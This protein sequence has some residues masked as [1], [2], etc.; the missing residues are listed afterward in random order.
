MEQEL[1][2]CRLCKCTELVE[3]INLGHQIIT[4][5]FPLKGDTSTPSAKI[6]IIQCT[7]C[8][9][10]QL[11]DTT[12]SSE[13]YEDFYGYRSGIN[14]TMRNHLTS[15]NEQLQSYANLVPGDT[16]LDIGSNDC[17]F[18]GHYPSTVRRIG[19]DPTGTQFA[20]FYKATGT[21][22]VPT[23][24][25][26]AAITASL[27][28]EVRFKSVSSISMFYDLPDP[29]Q[30]A[31]DIYDRLE[32]DGVWTLEQSYVATMLERNSIDTVCH[33][34]L[35]YYGVKQIKEIMDRVGFK[36][37]DL[38]LNDCNGGSFRTFVAKRSSIKFQE[39]TELVDRILAKEEADRI[40]TPERYAEFMKTCSTEVAKLN[41]FL[42]L[43][44]QDGKVTYIYGASTKGNC[45]LQFANIDSSKTPYAVERNPLKVGRITATGVEI[46][47]E[48]TMRQNPPDYMLVLPWH[49]RKEMIEREHAFLE[50]G[51]QLLFPFPSFEV[52]SS[53]PKTLI[54]GIDGQ[55]GQHLVKTLGSTVNLYGI[56]KSAAASKG[57]LRIRS[58]LTDRAALESLLC[59]IR[60]DQL[61]HLASLSNTEECEA[62]PVA[63]LDLNAGVVTSLCDIV[64]RNKLPTKLFHA[65]SS[66]LFKGHGNYVIEE[67]DTN[68]RP[69]T[70]YAICKAAGHSV[71]DSYR[72][73][74]G[75]P[76]SNGILF[77]TE[78]KLRK[79]TFLLKKVALHAKAV[80][81]G[82]NEP[83]VLGSLT[84]YRTI[85][86]ASDVAAAI[87]LVL[88]Q[89]RGD[90]YLICAP[91]SQTTEELVVVIYK[92]HGILLEKRDTD[93]YNRETGALV[94][95]TNRNQHSRMEACVKITGHCQRLAGLGWKP[96]YTVADVLAD[97]S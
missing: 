19:C 81:D 53:K 8:K 27:G 65:S 13:L 35:E 20:D 70:M 46:I 6:R 11:K 40:H 12:H 59:L 47:S 78:S 30:F 80:Q 75:L 4:S 73:R 29:V 26:K 79:P 76:F 51:G 64:Y 7:S 90:N 60:P 67:D 3:V 15:Y 22:L 39:A 69:A 14:A 28:S 91:N 48:E 18:I 32:D 89:P 10:V 74:H 44:K 57:I 95:K 43:A 31:Q 1:F 38:S 88:A 2:A 21:E 33:E 93:F 42:D 37:I 54:T 17:T 86:H 52:Y 61:V 16:V 77:T 25:T 9:L 82:S 34:H 85:T 56:T 45:L 83:L 66:D 41:Q 62:D 5:R 84:S 87:Q 23:Y 71:V 96:A 72:T 68:F 24:F 49:F 50:G 92:Q 36:I 94:V 97:M 58:D 55:I 63:T